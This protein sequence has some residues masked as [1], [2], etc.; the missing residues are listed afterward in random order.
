MT[1][2]VRIRDVDGLRSVELDA[3]ERNLLDPHTMGLLRDALLAADA[4]SA[5]T[6]ILL[7]STG[8]VFCGGLDIAAIR[9]GADPVE[10]ATAL[11]QLLQLL[12]RLTKPIAAA[13]HGDALAG[14]AALVAAVDFAVAVPTARIGSHEVSVGIWPMV[15]QVP[16]VHRIGLRAALENI[17]CGEPF[18]AVRAREVG[19]VQD[20]VEPA[21]LVARVT[22]W[23]T[24]AQ[25]GA[26]A[27]ALGRPSIYELA[28]LDYDV[29]LDAALIRFS[30]M[31]KESS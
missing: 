11:V 13:V 9:A 31:F 21:Q 23:L 19:L 24:K 17:G 4:D 14:G 7:T 28:E 29:A 10:F 25:R 30:S 15:A 6:G 2:S 27:Y 16:L 20:V 3:G 22:D 18:T 1:G 5:V 8:A 12:P 26:G